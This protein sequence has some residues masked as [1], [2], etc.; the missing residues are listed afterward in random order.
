MSMQM[1]TRR[2]ALAA[3][4]SMTGAASAPAVWAQSAARYPSRAVKMITGGSV[5]GTSDLMG[6]LIGE[7]LA[8][9][10]G[11]P[12]VSEARP[13]ANQAIAMK[14]VASA[15]P[16]GHALLVATTAYTL[17]LALRPDPGF[18]ESELAPISHLATAPTVLVVSSSLGVETMEQFLKLVHASPSGKFSYGSTGIGSAPNF[19]GEL[20][21][22]NQKFNIVH[23]PYK[24]ESALV[25]DLIA[26]TL[27]ATW[28]TAQLMG[29]LAK[30]GKVKI[31]AVTGDKRLPAL[32]DVPTS[33]EVGHP[34]LTGYWGMWTTGGTPAPI[35]RKIVDET[36]RTIAMPDVAQQII[37]MGFLPIGSGPEEFS[38]FLDAEFKRWKSVADAAKITLKD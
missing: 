36:R 2:Q 13:G 33:V 9:A 28:G 29:P 34:M 8:K 19:N 14:A 35:V 27:S 22:L 21:N 38:S 7:R 16:D 25:T 26:G 10:W 5:G 3:L 24:G 20:L 37:S 12:C 30:A 1:P 18:R 31:L 32:P 23:V 17:N 11:Q 15:A 4:A 6:R